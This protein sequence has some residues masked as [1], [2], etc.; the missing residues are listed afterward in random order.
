[1]LCVPLLSLCSA[2]AVAVQCSGVVA[3]VLL[4]ITSLL[5]RLGSRHVTVCLFS[6]SN[7]PW[8]SGTLRICNPGLMLLCW[9]SLCH[10]ILQNL[11]T[12][13]HRLRSVCCLGRILPSM[14]DIGSCFNDARTVPVIPGSWLGVK[15]LPQMTDRHRRTFHE[16]LYLNAKKSKKH[17][18]LVRIQHE[19]VNGVGG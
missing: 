10:S 8:N 5:L 11:V 15:S 7:D 1:M 17:F 13:F 12:N 3:F 6:G 18:E 19:K 4:L 2:A 16:I 14:Q 9:N